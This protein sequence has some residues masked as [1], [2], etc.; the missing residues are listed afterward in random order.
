MNI[1]NIKKKKK[2]K[3]IEAKNEKN[4]K[5]KKIMFKIIC[6]VLRFDFS[7]AEIKKKIHYIFLYKNKH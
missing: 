1:W 5:L 7:Y 4:P 6:C 2:I 3:K